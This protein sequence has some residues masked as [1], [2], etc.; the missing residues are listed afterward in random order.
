MKRRYFGTDGVRGPFGGPLIN[1]T[2]ARRL[3]AAA[4]RFAKG[5]LASP[6]QAPVIIGR[7]TRASGLELEFAVAEG[8]RSQGF[9]VVSVGA[10]PTPVVS[11]AVRHYRAPFGVV[12]TASHNP[13]ADNGIKFFSGSGTK[14][15][16]AHEVE[17]ER[18]L[19]EIDQTDLASISPALT[20]IP[21]VQL[22]NDSLAGVLPRRALQGW[23]VAV[24]CSNGAAVATTPLVLERLGA[25]VIRVGDQPDG[26]NINDGVGSQHPEVLADRVTHHRAKLGIAHDGDADRLVLVDEKGSVL[27]GDELLAIVA[28]RALSKGELRKKTLVA[29][30][31]SNL[32]LKVAIEGWGGELVQTSVGDRYVVEAMLEGGYS[33]GGESSGHLIFMDVSPSGDGLVAALKVIEAMIDSGEPLSE[34]RK[35]LKRFPQ[36]VRALKVA[37]KPSLESL[38]LLKQAVAAGETELKGEGRILLRYSGTEPRIRLLVEGPDMSRTVAVMDALEVVVRNELDV[39]E[40]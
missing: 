40:D 33:I 26:R 20:V 9:Q 8:I 25:E 18:L 16:D 11:F 31:Q 6:D 27:D 24:D 34:L 23:T 5:T 1:P 37:A 4:A 10:A 28:R 13:A 12:I 2:F 35:C 19:E 36:V 38:P 7:D 21:A 32:G 30:V 17:I 15:K 29:T 39:L 14:L 22:Y 3:G